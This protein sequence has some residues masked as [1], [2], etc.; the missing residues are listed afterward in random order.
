MIDVLD[1]QTSNIKHIKY[2]YFIIFLHFYIFNIVQHFF[3]KTLFIHFVFVIFFHWKKKK[4]NH[5]KKKVQRNYWKKKPLKKEMVFRGIFCHVAFY[6]QALRQTLNTKKRDRVPSK[7]TNSCT[8]TNVDCL[9]V[10]FLPVDLSGLVVPARG[11]RASAGWVLRIIETHKP[12]H[13]GKVAAYKRGASIGF[14]QYFRAS[15][16]VTGKSKVLWIVLNQLM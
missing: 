13:H 11:S 3:T 10:W 15:C 14:S 7:I 9:L 2:Y 1:W 5:W 12:L 8:A 4:R 16:I 6:L